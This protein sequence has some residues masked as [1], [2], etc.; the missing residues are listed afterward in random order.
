LHRQS[1]CNGSE[2][3]GRLLLQG[4]SGQCGEICL[5][6]LDGLGGGLLEPR[7]RL[8]W[9]WL[10]GGAFGEVAAEHQLGLAVA[11]LGGGA[12]SALGGRPVLGQVMAARIERAQ[13]E[14]RAAVTLAG[15]VLEQ[16]PA[17]RRC[18][19]GRRGR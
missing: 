15:G 11:E 17:P 14:H 7:A 13:R 3:E 16:V 12:E 10:A 2:S 1:P 9:V 6:F 19:A 4:Y 5:G 18:R 8:R